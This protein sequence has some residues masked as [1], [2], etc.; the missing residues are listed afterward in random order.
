MKNNF[1]EQ[2]NPVQNE[3][4]IPKKEGEQ[5]PVEEGDLDKQEEREQQKQLIEELKIKFGLDFVGN[6][7]E[8]VAKARKGKKE[9]LIN[10][11]GENILGEEFRFIS[12]GFSEQNVATVLDLENKQ[13]IIDNNGKVVAEIPEGH[14][15]FI[16]GPSDGK[17]IIWDRAGD[18]SMYFFDEEGQI[19]GRKFDKDIGYYYE[20]L[21]GKKIN[22]IV[23]ISRFRSGFAKF[24]TQSGSVG[25]MNDK[26]RVLDFVN[27]GNINNPGNGLI[28]Y[29]KEGEKITI[30][31]EGNQVEE[32]V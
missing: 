21:D 26:G 12:G 28:T 5:K 6:F 24:E 3:K 10:E 2:F 17:T 1:G 11:K 25:I 18:K 20:D 15:A 27:I 16:T 4:D 13:K 30:D 29:E 14:V 7:N 23:E 8:G 22:N 19:P 31:S 9:F 32:T